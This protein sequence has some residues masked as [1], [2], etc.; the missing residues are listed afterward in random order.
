LYIA[1]NAP[2]PLKVDD[3]EKCETTRRCTEEVDWP[4]EVHRMYREEHLSAGL[5]ISSA[6][7]WFFENEE[8]GIILEDDIL[9]HQDFFLYCD[10]LLERYKNNPQIQ[11]ISGYNFFFEGYSSPVSYYMSNF[12]Q[13]W[14]W[15]SWRR[16]WQTYVFDANLLD[17]REYLRKIKGI[18]S[19]PTY[20][21]Y[22]AIFDKMQKNEND[23]WDY[24]F[25]FNQILYS[26]YS[27]IPYTN[28]VE[29]LGFGTVE[30]S[31]S[32]DTKNELIIR[33]INHKSSSILPIKH[34]NDIYRDINAE[35]LYAKMSNN[36]QLNIL[37]RAFRK[38]LR[39]IFSKQI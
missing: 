32:T 19:R 36:I 4:C 31:H 22:R 16:V 37:Q 29:N 27:I 25:F 10:E 8:Q 1:A 11:L 6:I 17:R 12:L 35:Q 5:S 30:A 24:Q 21:Y 3:C 13:I 26:R 18:F 15:A 39:V 20:R 9:P 7:T 14:G 28:L 23:T 33:L 2:N 34:P 38:V